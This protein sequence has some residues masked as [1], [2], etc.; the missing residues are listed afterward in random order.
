METV[1]NAAETLPNPPALR[2]RNDAVSD[3]GRNGRGSGA[4]AVSEGAAI[5]QMIE[6]AAR[7]PSV[8]LD[9]MERLF[10]MKE[11][12]DAQR[13]KTSYL[14]ALALMQPAL[15]VVNKAGEIDRKAKDDAG[16]T[17]AAKPT[18]YAKWEDVVEAVNPILTEHG[19][20]LSFRIAQPSPDRIVVTAVL[21][22]RDGHSEETSMSLPIDNSGAKNNVQGWGSSV[23]YGK[24]YT[25]FALLNIV[26][27]GEDDDGNAAGRVKELDRDAALA[28]LR[29]L[30]QKVGA[31]EGKICNHFSVESFDDLTARQISEASAGLSA[32]LRKAKP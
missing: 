21:G 3:D 6:R 31:D 14:N 18:K 32:R 16:V 1:K 22:H 17:K 9:K 27:R 13:A 29:A 30:V 10:A 20:S 25:A 23:S 15:P 2:D 19:F 11:R 24:R 26:A 28:A 4:V 7:D 8:D 12:M 5:I